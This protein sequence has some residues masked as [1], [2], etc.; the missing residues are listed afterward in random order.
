MIHWDVSRSLCLVVFVVCSA[1][2]KTS[3]GSGN[4]ASVFYVGLTQPF[5]T[6]EESEV[7]DYMYLIHESGTLETP[8]WVSIPVNFTT[9][10]L[11]WLGDTHQISGVVFEPIPSCSYLLLLFACG[12]SEVVDGKYYDNGYYTAGITGGFFVNVAGGSCGPWSSFDLLDCVFD[13][14][15]KNLELLPIGSEGAGPPS[16]TRAHVVT[17]VDLYLEG[18]P[19]YAIVTKPITGFSNLTTTLPAPGSGTGN[20]SGLPQNNTVVLR[21]NLLFQNTLGPLFP[22]FGKATELPSANTWFTVDTQ[23]V[24]NSTWAA[25]NVTFPDLAPQDGKDPGTSGL[26]SLL[27]VMTCV[28]SRAPGWKVNFTG[29]ETWDPKVWEVLPSEA[30]LPVSL[31]PSGAVYFEETAQAVL[32]NSSSNDGGLR[33]VA[34]DSFPVTT[35]LDADTSNLVTAFPSLESGCASAHDYVYNTTPGADPL[36]KSVFPN[37]WIRK[38]PL[39]KTATPMVV[40]IGLN[41]VLTS[42]FPF[43][44]IVTTPIQANISMDTPMLFNFSSFGTPGVFQLRLSVSLGFPTL[45]TPLIVWSNQTV[46]TTNCDNEELTAFQSPPMLLITCFPV[47]MVL[48]VVVSIQNTSFE[49]ID[50][51]W[52]FSESL[53]LP[54]IRVTVD[55][56]SSAPAPEAFSLLIFPSLDEHPVEISSFAPGFTTAHVPDVLVDESSLFALATPFQ[57]TGFSEIK[58]AGCNLDTLPNTLA[59]AL[60][61]NADRPALTYLS[62]R[63]LTVFLVSD[64]S[65]IHFGNPVFFQ[66]TQQ[67]SVVSDPGKVMCYTDTGL[68]VTIPPLT[69]L[70]HTVFDLDPANSTNQLAS[71][72]SRPLFETAVFLDATN[73]YA[74]QFLRPS[75]TETQVNPGLPLP[76]QLSPVTIAIPI[77]VDSLEDSTTG[78][79]QYSL[80]GLNDPLLA[81]THVPFEVLQTALLAGVPN[82]VP[83]R[84]A[85]PRLLPGCIDS[86]VAYLGKDCLFLVCTPL[87]PS[88]PIS[89]TL[90]ERALPS[91]ADAFD[92]G[93]GVN[94]N[95]VQVFI[96]TLVGMGPTDGAGPRPGISP[97]SNTLLL[98]PPSASVSPAP[99]S[100]PTASMS[101]SPSFS[102][103]TSRTR[104]QS[105]SVTLTVTTSATRSATRSTTGSKSAS[106]SGSASRSTSMSGS[107]SRSTSVSGSPS[108]SSSFSS[109]LSLLPS[110]SPMDTSVPAPFGLPM[111]PIALV[112]WEYGAPNCVSTPLFRKMTPTGVVFTSPTPLVVPWFAF[113]QGSNSVQFLILNA[114]YG[115]G[116]GASNWAGSQP[117]S[118]L[119][120]GVHT[121]TTG[122]VLQDQ[123]GLIAS[124]FTGGGDTLVFEEIPFCNGG[125]PTGTDALAIQ[126]SFIPQ[127]ATGNT[128]Q[129]LLPAGAFQGP[130]G[131]QF[132]LSEVPLVQV[133]IV[134]GPESASSSPSTSPSQSTS[135]SPSPFYPGF[136]S[137]RRVFLSVGEGNMWC[138]SLLMPTVNV[139]WTLNLGGQQVDALFLGSVTPPSTSGTNFMTVVVDRPGGLNVAVD[140]WGIDSFGS[141]SSFGSATT[142]GWDAS[143]E[144]CDSTSDGINEAT[145]LQQGIVDFSVII[146]VFTLS[147][148]DGGFAAFFVTMGDVSPTAT[149]SVSPSATIPPS[150]SQ[151][152]SASETTTVSGTT[153]TS[154]SVSPS[155]SPSPSYSGSFSSSETVSKSFS[156]SPTPGPMQKVDVVGVALSTSLQ[157]VWIP[158]PS[159]AVSFTVDVIG[160]TLPP[161]VE[162]DIIGNATISSAGLSDPPVL[163]AVLKGPVPEDV[164][165]EV[166]RIYTAF[167]QLA[168]LE[169]GASRTIANGVRFD[170][171][172]AGQTIPIQCQE[173]GF[174]AAVDET[175]SYLEFATLEPGFPLLVPFWRKES[176]LY[177]GPGWGIWLPFNDQAVLLNLTIVVPSQTAS[178]SFSASPSGSASA[179]ASPSPRTLSATASISASPTPGP[180]LKLPVVGFAVSTSVQCV[181]VPMPD[182]ATQM[183]VVVTP[184][185]LFP[186][187]AVETDVVGN[188][189][190]SSIG[191]S[192]IPL[193]W[194]VLGALVTADVADGTGA[195]SQFFQLS[196]LGE[197]A[198]QITT[199]VTLFDSS[200]MTLPVLCQGTGLA[201]A[202]AAEERL[203]FTPVEPGVSF[204]VPFWPANLLEYHSGPMLPTDDQAVLLNLTILTVSPST[205]RSVSVSV[206]VSPSVSPSVSV[207]VSV[208]VSPSTSQ[209]TTLSRTRT[210]S[211]SPST[212][213]SVTTSVSVSPTLSPTT[214]LSGT[215]TP[216]LTSSTSVSPSVTTTTSVSPSVTQT[217]VTGSVNAEGLFEVQEMFVVNQDSIFP[218]PLSSAI[219][220]NG[221][222][223]FASFY[224]REIKLLIGFLPSTTL[225]MSILI[226]GQP[227]VTE[228]ISPAQ[229]FGQTLVHLDNTSLVYVQVS[230]ANSWQFYTEFTDR[231]GAGYAAT[232]LDSGFVTW[233]VNVTI[234][235]ES[236]G[237]GAASLPPRAQVFLFE[238]IGQRIT[239][240]AVNPESSGVSVRSFEPFLEEAATE[241]GVQNG[242]T[243]TTTVSTG[244]TWHNFSVTP[245]WLNVRASKIVVSSISGTSVPQNGAQS[246]VVTTTVS[247]CVSGFQSSGFGVGTSISMAIQLNTDTESC[248]VSFAV[249][250]LPLVFLT[251]L[252]LAF[253]V[254]SNMSTEAGLVHGFVKITEFSLTFQ[255]QTTPTIP[256]GVLFTF[257]PNPDTISWGSASCSVFAMQDGGSL[258]QQLASYNAASAPN[259]MM[260]A[261]WYFT[262]VP[263]GG[264][265]VGGP[266]TSMPI[267]DTA[268]DVIAE[269]VWLDSTM[270][271]AN[272][273]PPCFETMSVL[274]SEFTAAD[275]VGVAIS[276]WTVAAPTS[277]AP[278]A[279]IQFGFPV[280]YFPSVALNMLAWPLVPIPTV[281][282]PIVNTG[283]FPPSATSL[284]GINF[285]PLSAF[286]TWSSTGVCVS[287]ILVCTSQQCSPDQTPGI[288][289][290]SPLPPDT[291]SQTV[292]TVVY[293]AFDARFTGLG[294]GSNFSAP[295]AALNCG[296]GA[297]QSFLPS[298]ATVSWTAVDLP[299]WCTP[300]VFPVPT[301]Q[302]VVLKWTFP[303]SS[304]C[305]PE[306]T[307]LVPA[308]AFVATG[309]LLSAPKVGQ[310]PLFM[311]TQFPPTVPVAV[312]FT[313]AASNSPDSWGERQCSLFEIDVSN[314]VP[315]LGN[316]LAS[317]GSAADPQAAMLAVWFFTGVPPGGYGLNP[318]STATGITLNGDYG[319]V[320]VPS[321]LVP[322]STNPDDLVPSACFTAKET[323][324]S[325]FDAS[326]LPGFIM[327]M[328]NLTVAEETINYLTLINYLSFQLGENTFQA[329][330]D[331]GITH[332]P[333][334]SIQPFSI[335]ISQIQLV[336]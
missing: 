205:T 94:P 55:Q 317:V 258:G 256:V 321:T 83:N 3:V 200:A 127:V 88:L 110:L 253:P 279:A 46:R 157:C 128:F 23:G 31:R 249:F 245:Q 254:S 74:V 111:T 308:N 261:F 336:V 216:S 182:S 84:D 116:S 78:V 172:Y 134:F 227:A 241:F 131:V 15:F 153:T 50:G 62:S 259:T 267:V 180:L 324:M 160:D 135:P 150:L 299:S 302:A 52:V 123:L 154:A 4:E 68:C 231:I 310:P 322:M 121:M 18:Q 93:S 107:A 193:L 176:V 1:T 228:V 145:I 301:V 144:W 271:P 264:Y 96:D 89:V 174:E 235:A 296:P 179:S 162:T 82:C 248:V 81:V 10:V 257:T 219:D 278:S 242:S 119:E 14:P 292:T 22:A 298:S 54:D 49:V 330:M 250:T 213:V 218:M 171:S 103:T 326:E 325:Q 175:G 311:Q 202:A 246:G 327:T 19:S 192:D 106:T 59:N 102:G 247:G 16:G 309:A 277:V 147:V 281:F 186:A 137:I 152:M 64:P 187:R 29:N 276:M 215:V 39:N 304:R 17:W 239:P 114:T 224:L 269:S 319:S 332:W 141:A 314:G 156:A 101:P 26:V 275:G 75:M 197:G 28:V 139:W 329:S 58:I 223:F 90:P 183:S 98:F 335:D 133:P 5:T 43:S 104:S 316:Q 272:F 57:T 177:A 67:V 69:F 24:C 204:L 230:L 158:M 221:T 178:I 265:G 208:S 312:M 289:I 190:I 255:W 232:L 240:V 243:A 70:W 33:L 2:L 48:P 268:G 266:H 288:Q 226:Q 262:G 244:L 294:M 173:N 136:L 113:G 34:P 38:T 323:F 120:C 263:P 163:W 328:W 76:D 44:Q 161:W 20:C 282:V 42:T 149:S 220:S 86:G 300:P 40:S 207:S 217:P 287:S 148:S 100:S 188:V 305:L 117:P 195:V 233:L 25:S 181:W 201:T 51:A 252:D 169:D 196:S 297:G 270:N 112:F 7:F 284:V 273:A 80:A 126:R 122:G 53:D 331:L 65:C 108:T 194:I 333:R 97:K 209:T 142:V 307:L 13:V 9:V 35:I 11:Q 132:P 118:D 92:D 151:T 159:P 71:L 164:G 206:S 229:F 91:I 211:S 185:S 47:E 124:L 303:T 73:T 105:S 199:A 306:T 165:G 318:P 130:G 198:S 66:G 115:L 238:A 95:T 212:T 283:F 99:S 56:N 295:T 109:S 63:Q 274:L 280:G 60:A 45:I 285:V 155:T 191:P 210:T 87:N 41:N 225:P 293:R 170:G 27:F 214:T 143:I 251:S 286:L 146:Q 315:Q 189:T 166:P 77:S 290:S 12:D 168:S 140:F 222:T 8:L 260:A 167:Y 320:V 203:E 236:V 37:L 313:F 32:L 72:P 21:I 334:E 125:N 79:A 6:T 30:I 85:I 138:P 36:V 237:I 129:C 61:T 234:P 291:G 184:D